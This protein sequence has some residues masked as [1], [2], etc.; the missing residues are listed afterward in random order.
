MTPMCERCAGNLPV[1]EF[2]VRVDGELLCA[3]CREPGLVGKV[4]LFP[5]RPSTV[6]RMATQTM[7]SVRGDVRP[8]VERHRAFRRSLTGGDR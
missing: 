2:P 1:D 3:I 5:V 7:E 6:E 4:L 8:A